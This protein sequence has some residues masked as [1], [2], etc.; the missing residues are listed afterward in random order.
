MAYIHSVLKFFVG[1]ATAALIAWKLTV[2]IAIIIASNPAT[3]KI[4]GLMFILYSNFCNQSCMIH[5]AAGNDTK[6]AS[7]TNCK[8]SFDNNVAIP[9]ILAPNTFRIPIS[10]I[11]RSAV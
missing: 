5:H 2:I 7:P 4:Q 9:A 11:L 3:I 8:K 10:F 1:F 6:Q